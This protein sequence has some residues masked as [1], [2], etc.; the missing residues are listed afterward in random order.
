MPIYKHPQGI[1]MQCVH[2]ENRVSFLKSHLTMVNIFLDSEHI[3]NIGLVLL[4]DIVCFKLVCLYIIFLPQ[5]SLRFDKLE[6]CGDF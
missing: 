2:K 4:Y 5:I 6:F 1:E 3:M